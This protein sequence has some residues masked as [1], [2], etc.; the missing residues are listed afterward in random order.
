LASNPQDQDF[1]QLDPDWSTALVDIGEF[2]D[3]QWSFLGENVENKIYEKSWHAKMIIPPEE[4]TGGRKTGG[5]SDVQT[6]E[7]TE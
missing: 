6:K 4:K 3:L 1:W 2:C 5:Y 7:K